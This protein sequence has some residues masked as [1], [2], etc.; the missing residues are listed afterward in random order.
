MIDE[1]D[2]EQNQRM[3]TTIRRKKKRGKE[4]KK[5]T[6]IVV[7][8]VVSYEVKNGLEERQFRK[9]KQTKKNKKN[10]QTKFKNPVFSP[11]P[12]LLEHR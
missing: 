2:T 6:L 1:K 7:I 9:R 12:I 5:V 11:P 3:R 8:V 4:E 10:T